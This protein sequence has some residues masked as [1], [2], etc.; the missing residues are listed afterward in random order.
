MELGVLCSGGLGYSTLVQLVDKYPINF[1]F[2]DSKSIS[3]IDLCRNKSIPVFIGNP[4]KGKAKKII[5][6]NTCNVLIS[7][8]YLFI[9][10][11]DVINMGSDLTFNIHGSLLPKYR[12]RTPHVW[13]IINDEKQ[14]GITAHVIDEGCDTGNIIEQVVIPIDIKD[15]GN[16]VLVKY[17]NHYFPLIEKVITKYK[18]GTLTF[19]S[20][21]EEEATYFGKR[22]HLDGRI[23]WNWQR[24]R[25]FN[26]VRAQ[27]SPYP[28]AF[29]FYQDE[30]LI[31]DEV[32]FS[33]YGFNYSMENGQILSVEPLLIKTPNGVLKV[34]SMRENIKLKKGALLI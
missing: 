7:I 24:K 13:A 11:E 29:T 5:E 18:E 28:G 3:I 15:T 9:I 21:K 33:N 20:Q 17:H 31:I 12:G 16:D 32:S 10:E 1:V 6:E 25:I 26:W 27:A 23:N 30:K 4:R 34:K 2:T 14:T 22:T 19:K 8:N